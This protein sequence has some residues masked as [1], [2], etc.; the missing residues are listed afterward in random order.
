MSLA[1]RRRVLIKYMNSLRYCF[2]RAFHFVLSTVKRTHSNSQH[3][4]PRLMTKKNSELKARKISR[5]APIR[6]LPF[7]LLCQQC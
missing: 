2:N 5:R 6:S 7:S 4:E 1:L 3:P